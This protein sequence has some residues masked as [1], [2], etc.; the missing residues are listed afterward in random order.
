[1]LHR[2]KA[3]SYPFDLA[4]EI[5]LDSKRFADSLNSDSTRQKLFDEIHAA[6][7]IGVN[8]FPSLVL[9]D[10]GNLRHILVDYT[11]LDAL[12]RQIDAL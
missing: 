7:S 8:S 2:L 10:R 4:A 12:L 6:R 11:N 9:E 3:N 5:G 1:M